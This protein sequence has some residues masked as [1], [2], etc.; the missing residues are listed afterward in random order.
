MKD[1]VV[2]HKNGE[3][4]AMNMVIG[5]YLREMGRSQCVGVHIKTTIRALSNYSSELFLHVVIS[6]VMTIGHCIC[7]S[8]EHFSAFLVNFEII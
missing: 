4:L 8:I 3:D 7:Y 5:K 1:F 6:L 2:E